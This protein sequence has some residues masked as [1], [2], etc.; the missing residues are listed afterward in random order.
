M[1]LTAVPPAVRAARTAPAPTASHAATAT[2]THTSTSTRPGHRSHGSRTAAA[3][4]SVAA[5][6]I[7]I[8][9]TVDHRRTS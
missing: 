3:T 1:D 2:A 4:E 7:P 9:N 5:A 8:G 6:V